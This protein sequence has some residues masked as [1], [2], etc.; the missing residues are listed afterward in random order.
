MGFL[1]LFWHLAGLFAP[2]LVLAPG[3][4]GASRLLV[5]RPGRAP[6]WRCQLVSNLAACLLVL[7]AGL[8]LS[9][10]DGRMATYAA[11]VL[12]SSVCQAWLL[13]QQR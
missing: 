11:L 5:R 2:A 13:R 10:H 9:G 4:V 3:V 8:L 12:V 7:L 1:D 6:T